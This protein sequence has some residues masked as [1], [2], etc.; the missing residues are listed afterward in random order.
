MEQNNS[1]P[2]ENYKQVERNFGKMLVSNFLGGIAWSL[3]VLI[4]TSIVFSLIAII[5]SKINFVPI[6]GNFLAKVLESAQSTFN[7]R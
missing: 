4:G 1:Q 2:G 5:I 3:G 6:F 7:T